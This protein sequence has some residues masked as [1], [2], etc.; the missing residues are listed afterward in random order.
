[1]RNESSTMVAM[2]DGK[3]VGSAVAIAIVL[4]AAH[5]HAD[6]KTSV[7]PPSSSVQPLASDEEPTMWHVG[8]DGRTDLGAHPVRLPIGIRKGDWDGTIVLD[9]YAIL[10][11]Q[12]DLDVLA[13]WYVGPRVGLLAGWRWTA[14]GI[15]NGLVSQE[16]ALV[17]ITGV[18]P[19]FGRVHTS[20]SLELATFIVAHGDTKTEWIKADRDFLDH[21]SFGLFV[22]FDYAR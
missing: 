14:I 21:F 18:G 4:F 16:R 15:A 11:G 13:E 22:R 12:H 7:Q 10:D 9:P 5:A 17:G 2:L 19:T 6:V 1:M 3:R 20:A 8:I